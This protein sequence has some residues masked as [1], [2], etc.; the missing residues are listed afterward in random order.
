MLP[1]ALRSH[2]ARAFWE[3]PT[4]L[5]FLARAFS[6][7]F[8]KGVP[9]GS[10]IDSLGEFLLV[11]RKTD[12]SASEEPR[13]RLARLPKI[14]VSE[15]TKLCASMTFFLLFPSVEDALRGKEF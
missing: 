1:S 2:E 15:A 11:E 4:H 9:N 12:D 3:G 6:P 8:I 5:F 10:Q 14:F 13:A 7:F